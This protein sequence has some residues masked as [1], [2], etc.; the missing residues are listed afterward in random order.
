[1]QEWKNNFQDWVREYERLETTLIRYADSECSMEDLFQL[2]GI[3]DDATRVSYDIALFLE[4]K[5]RISK[6]ESAVSDG[7]DKAERDVLAK[8]L[9]DKLRSPKY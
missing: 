7:L 5:E 1:M 6:F 2:Q 8:I 4:S 3:L 9:T